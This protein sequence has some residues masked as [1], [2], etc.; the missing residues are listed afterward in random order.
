MGFPMVNPMAMN[1]YAMGAMNPYAMA[2][3]GLGGCGCN[4][5]G[6]NMGMMGMQQGGCGGCNQSASYNADPVSNIFG[7]I[8]GSIG[9]IFKYGMMAY[10]MFLMMQR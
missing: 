9:T 4:G 5:M 7:S 6:N 8:G 3:M 10:S 2:G 1:P